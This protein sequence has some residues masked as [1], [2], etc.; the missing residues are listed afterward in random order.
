MTIGAIVASVIAKSADRAADAAVDGSEGAVRA[1]VRKI[2]ERFASA[3]D[4]EA[5][6]ALELARAAPDSAT[7]VARFGQ[8]IDRHA[9]EDSP[10]AAELHAWIDQT[11]AAGIQI[12]AVT[13][14]AT[15]DGNVQIGGLAAGQISVGPPHPPTNDR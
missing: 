13:Q 14:N 4:D 6:A 2:R 3:G 7:A 1:L 8:A 5:V 10:F 11:Q 12:G 9:P 15:G